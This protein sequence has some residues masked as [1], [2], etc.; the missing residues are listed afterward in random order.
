VARHTLGRASRAYLDL[1]PDQPAQQEAVVSWPSSV[2]DQVM[3]VAMSA[4]TVHFADQARFR[5]STSNLVL[6]ALLPV[7][8]RFYC[9]VSKPEI[10]RTEA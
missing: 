4:A 2:F 3:T 5:G 8:S 7:L 10:R 6:G 1:P 9:T